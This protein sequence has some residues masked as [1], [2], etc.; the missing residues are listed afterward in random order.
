MLKF[1]QDLC[2]LEKSSYLFSQH[3]LIHIG[4]EFRQPGNT[5]WWATYELYVRL[6]TNWDDVYTSITTAIIDGDVGEDGARV[7]RLNTLVTDD[8]SRAKLRLEI[9]FVV[10]VA[11]PLVQTNYLLEGDG[12]CS[13]IA[14]DSLIQCKI[15]FESNFQDLSFPSLLQEID[16]AVLVLSPLSFNNDDLICKQTLINHVRESI[17]PA[18]N[19]FMTKIFGDLASDIVIYKIL[20][21]ANPFSIK[22]LNYVIDLNEFRNNLLILGHFTEVE[23]NGILNE[24]STYLL[25]C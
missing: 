11:K 17:R 25:L 1:K 15:W 2:S 20:R 3:W 22:R 8:I 4:E 16:L 23:L 24:V 13:L 14:Y 18:Y 7:N 10:I 19:Y 9:A 6:A 12:P 5:R 21:I